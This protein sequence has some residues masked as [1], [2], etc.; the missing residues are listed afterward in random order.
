MRLWLLVLTKTG[1]LIFLQ[2]EMQIDGANSTNMFPWL[3]APGAD[4]MPQNVVSRPGTDLCDRRRL[5]QCHYP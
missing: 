4:G 2:S 5:W 3:G 1:V